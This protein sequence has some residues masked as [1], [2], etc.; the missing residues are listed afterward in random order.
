MIKT[1]GL[2]VLVLVGATASAAPEVE[3]RVASNGDVPVNAL[4]A[5][6]EADGRVL[7]VCRASYRRGLHLGKLRSE[8]G[9]CKIPYGGSEKVIAVY[10]VLIAI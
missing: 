1:V 10:Q 3:W 6:R 2:F 7:F 8:F 4:A 5:G 9:G